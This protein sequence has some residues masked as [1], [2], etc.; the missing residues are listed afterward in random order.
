MT[1]RAKLLSAGTLAL[2]MAATASQAAIITVDIH[3]PSAAEISSDAALSNATIIDLIV[4]SEGDLLL[5]YDIIL[6]TIGTLYNH[7]VEQPNDAAPSPAAVALIPALGADSH[8]AFGSVLGGN[9]GSPSGSF[10]LSVGGPLPAVAHNGLLARITVLN[11][12]NATITG[13]IYVSEDGVSSI[14]IE[15]PT[16]IEGD[17]NGDGFVGIAD[18]NI[19]LGDWNKTVPPADPAADPSGDNFVGIA[20]LNTVLGNW[21]AGTPPT[22]NAVPEPAG[23]ALLGLGGL[24]MLR[25]GSK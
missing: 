6:N 10:P 12:P 5:S 14:G 3:A 17:L 19:V 1:I 7:P 25:R 16:D 11:D 23:V 21:N 22:T 15:Y 2:A 13:T 18:L 9:L 4:D 24:A 20:D 8:V